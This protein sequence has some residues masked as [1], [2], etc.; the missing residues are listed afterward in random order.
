[1][2]PAFMVQAGVLPFKAKTAKLIKPFYFNNF[3][4]LTEKLTG[5]SPLSQDF[6]I[7]KILDSTRFETAVCRRYQIVRQ[8]TAKFYF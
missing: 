3:T 2:P 8:S 6:L 4:T 1:M 5:I 7:Y